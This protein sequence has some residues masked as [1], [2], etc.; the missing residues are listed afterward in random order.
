MSLTVAVLL[1]FLLLV[2]EADSKKGEFPFI[3]CVD[4]SWECFFMQGLVGLYCSMSA[5]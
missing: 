2:D 5:L 4:I 3:T 1:H